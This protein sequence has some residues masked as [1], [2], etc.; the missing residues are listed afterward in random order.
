MNELNRYELAADP[1]QSF[2][3]WFS[4]A[5]K[6]E[7]NPT[8]FTLATADKE[9]KPSART[10]L[11]KGHQKDQGFKFYTHASSP[12]GKDLAV[13]PRASMVF[14][15]HH[16]QRQVRLFG[17]VHKMT[18]E[19]SQAY[20]YSRDKESQM[21][22]LLSRQSHPIESREEL[23]KL[24]EATKLKYQGQDKVDFPANWSGYYLRPQSFEFFVYGAHRLNDR[25][26]YEHKA[27]SGW[28]VTRLQP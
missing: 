12:K 6:T 13:N 2:E 14:Y 4:Q 8:A 15:W 11:Y 21:A 25:F 27:K 23:E 9:G 24:F 17:D 28:V 5:E 18:Q 10:L 19:E 26:L 22:S 16:C 3:T 1:Y 20:F 7:E